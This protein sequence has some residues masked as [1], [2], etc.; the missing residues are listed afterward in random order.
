[1]NVYAMDFPW[2]KPAAAFSTAT[3]RASGLRPDKLHKNY[4][5][6]PLS[7]TGVGHRC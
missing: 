1:M 5:K 2:Q 6:N 4:T 7:K 3:N